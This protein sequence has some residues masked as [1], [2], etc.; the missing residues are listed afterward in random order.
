FL[1]TFFF[2]NEMQSQEN[3]G[4]HTGQIQANEENTANQII[5]E[6]LPKHWGTHFL[7]S[8]IRLPFKTLCVRLYMSLRKKIDLIFMGLVISHKSE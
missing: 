8:L 3:S 2:F 4:N 5:E 1:A 7:Y 6:N